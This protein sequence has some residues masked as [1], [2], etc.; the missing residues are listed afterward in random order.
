LGDA[1]HYYCELDGGGVAVKEGRIANNAAALE[2]FFARRAATVEAME[3]GTHSRWVSQRLEEWGHTALVGNPRKSKAIYASVAKSDERDA[4]MLARMARF[5]PQLLSPIRHRGER[6][7]S[8]LSILKARDG[9]VRS[10]TKLINQCRGLAKASGTRLPSC[11]ADSFARKVGES[12]PDSLI[13]ALAPLVRTIGEL[14][15]TIHGMDKRIETLCEKEYPETGSLSAVNGVG[16]LIS[17]GFVLTIE[18]PGRFGRARAVG[19]YV[20]LTTRRDQSGEVDKQL[21]ITKAGDAFLRRLLISGAHYILGPFGQDCDLRRWGLAM[22]ARG[23]KN[24][25]KRA[26]VAVARKLAVLLLRLWKSDEPYD[27][28]YLSR[29]KMAEKNP[30]ATP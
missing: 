29:G 28:F 16:P 4:R 1:Y 23:G 3:A 8:H 9:L 21:R 30:S 19:A 7:Q 10:R 17:L 25:R 18:D 20:G 24:A 27:P 12:I 14:T 5:D 6:A 11:S 22:C 15:K 26:I 2:R 13:E